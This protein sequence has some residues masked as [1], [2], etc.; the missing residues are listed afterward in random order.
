[1]DDLPQQVVMFALCDDVLQLT[2]GRLNILG[3]RTAFASQTFPI[4]DKM[5]A[6]MLFSGLSDE[7][8]LAMLSYR[9]PGS[10]D[11]MTLRAQTS[12]G[13]DQRRLC[14]CTMPLELKI[15]EPGDI[16]LAVAIDGQPLGIYRIPVFQ[17]E[18]G[19]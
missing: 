10:T 16:R 15:P 13:Q 6:F 7:P 9:L 17:R 19:P 18:W 14:L 8:H 2:N 1:M 3:A 4:I 12:E 5:K 11:Y